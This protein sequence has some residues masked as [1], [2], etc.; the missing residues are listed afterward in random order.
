MN[1]YVSDATKRAF[2][3]QFAQRNYTP[4]L[5][6]GVRVIYSL[7]TMIRAAI[8]CRITEG[9]VIANF[10][11]LMFECDPALAIGWVLRVRNYRR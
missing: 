9:P 1:D 5:F 8:L 7:L 2:E 10:A 6:L 3:G 4:S 11:Q